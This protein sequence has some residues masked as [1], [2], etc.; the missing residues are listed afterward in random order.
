M[1]TFMRASSD[2]RPGEDAIRDARV[3]VARRNSAWTELE[4]VDLVRRHRG[5]LVSA[6]TD[7]LFTL[8][9]G[10]VFAS[11]SVT[12]IADQA[13]LYF[14]VDRAGGDLVFLEKIMSPATW[15]EHLEQQA[16]KERRRAAPK[17][18]R[19]RPA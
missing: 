5:W 18:R 17:P 14:Y 3:E 12:V 13:A 10:V 11:G 15:T 9:R 4:E 16:A 6:E 1:R 2:E 8:S 7:E 19:G